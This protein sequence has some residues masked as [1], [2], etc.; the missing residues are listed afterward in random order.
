MNKEK[1]KTAITSILANLFYEKIEDVSNRQVKIQDIKEMKSLTIKNMPKESDFESYLKE[2]LKNALS[3]NKDVQQNL[4]E[5]EEATINSK[6]N[7]EL[8]K[9]IEKL[10]KSNARLTSILEGKSSTQAKEGQ[11]QEQEQDVVPPTI[12]DQVCSVCMNTFNTSNK[13]PKL[14]K[15]M[16][17]T[18]PDCKDVTKAVAEFYGNINAPLDKLFDTLQPE[19]ANIP[20]K[21]ELLAKK[22]ELTRENSTL[23]RELQK[24]EKHSQQ[25][26]DAFIVNTKTTLEQMETSTKLLADSIEQKFKGNEGT[27]PAINQQQLQ[28]IKDFQTQIAE[29]RTKLEKALRLSKRPTISRLVDNLQYLFASFNQL[30]QKHQSSLLENQQ[31]KV[32]ILDTAKRLSELEDKAKTIP[33]LEKQVQ[34]LQLALD[35]QRTASETEKSNLQEQI[36]KLKAEID[37]QKEV[38]KNKEEENS[39]LLQRIQDLEKLLK[40]LQD[41]QQGKSELSADQVAVLQQQ[42]LAYEEEIRQLKEKIQSLITD[43]AALKQ[44]HELEIKAKDEEIA[45][46]NK[47]IIEKDEEI[48]NLRKRADI[49]PEELQKLQDQN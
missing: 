13:R 32:H 25:E 45:R 41:D 31:L 4:A 7:S 34:G 35:A 24:K 6:I 23:T 29:N 48:T 10:Q 44:Q 2:K 22:A 5:L 36:D 49:T 26:I 14:N 42:K 39:K 43:I 16:G 1:L 40:Q 3:E 47:L 19:K 33:E 8:Q 11:E 37:R 28:E 18:T 21:Q 15:L 20:V 46:L 27:L 9:E 17:A 38:I 12:L 30:H